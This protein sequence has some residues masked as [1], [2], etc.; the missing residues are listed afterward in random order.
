MEA[1]QFC[2]IGGV[3]AGMSAA[4][5]IKRRLPDSSVVVLEAGHDVSYGA[6]GMPYNLAEPD[7][8]VN[9]LVVMSADQFREKRG[10][11][12]RLGHR[13]EA[14]LPSEQKVR[15]V[16]DRG[17]GFELDYDVLVLATGSRVTRPPIPGIESEACLCLRTLEDCHAIKSRLCENSCKRAVILGGSYLGL[18]LAEVLSLR[19]MEVSIV[20]RTPVM[21][22]SLP[23]EMDELLREELANHGVDVIHGSSVER[24]EP[25]SP[26]K[27]VLSDRELSADLVLAA[28]GF[29]PRSELAREAG[30]EPGAAGAVAVD[31]YGRTSEKHIFAAGD[32]CDGFHHVTGERVWVPLA[33]RANRTGRMV[34]ANAAGAWEEIPPVLGTTGQRVFDLE[35]AT[36]GLT[37]KQANKHG[38]NPVTATI[39]ART[40]AHAFPGAGWIRVHLVANR[41]DGRLL[42]AA[43]LG[44]EMAAIRIDVLAAAI[45][46]DMTVRQ[47]SNLDLL[48]SPPF[49]PAW[50]PVL[51]CANQLVKK[52][53]TA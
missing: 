43:V 42:G 18:E 13:V 52:A 30:L 6:C 41:D 11:D 4:S 25:G 34:G 48:Y 3:A 38:F 23:D 31:R 5:Q 24:I 44:E 20:K 12:L 36:T 46:A 17:G 29:E 40:R 21:L 15:G 14:I 22:K 47:L 26:G 7:R 2:V 10:L 19:G 50:D 45:Q 27:V 39:K 51:V 53:G 1:K 9:D 16:T 49:A 37:E 33:L 28:T 32:C 8:D 35:V